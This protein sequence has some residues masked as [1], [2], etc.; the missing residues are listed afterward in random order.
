MLIPDSVVDYGN[1]ILEDGKVNYGIKYLKTD[2]FADVKTK[3]YKKY[4]IIF[5]QFRIILTTIKIN[6]HIFIK[7]HISIINIDN[8]INQIFTFISLYSYYINQI[9]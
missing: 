9:R 2:I 1:S 3:S 4:N 7:K 8:F 6:F 5:Y